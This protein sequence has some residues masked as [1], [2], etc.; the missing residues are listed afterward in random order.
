[1]NWVQFMLGVCHRY[2]YGTA[3]DDIKA[4]E[5][6]TP[7]QV[8]RK[9]ALPL[10]CLGGCCQNKTKA[11]ELFEKSARLGYGGAMYLLGTCCKHGRGVTTDATQSQEW[12]AKAVV[13]RHQQMLRTNLF[14]PPKK[15]PTMVLFLCFGSV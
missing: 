7:N 9:T 5:C 13:Q 8:H 10:S 11:V 6:G 14:F 3:Q 4:R 12:L 2:G 1:M 15:T